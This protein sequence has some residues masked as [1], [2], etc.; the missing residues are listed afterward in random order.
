MPAILSQIILVRQ[1]FLKQIFSGIVPVFQLF[2]I[3][4][5][6]FPSL[7]RRLWIALSNKQ[8]LGTRV[9]VQ[10]PGVAPMDQPLV[11]LIEPPGLIASLAMALKQQDRRLSLVATDVKTNF[12][13][14]G[15]TNILEMKYYLLKYHRHTRLDSR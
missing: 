15:R 8:F 14:V 4:I 2:Q 5:F 3:D 6:H 9:T 1:H 13:T 11:G 10:T 7:C 12:L